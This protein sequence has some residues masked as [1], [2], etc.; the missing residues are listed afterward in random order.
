MKI[1][2][3]RAKMIP[4]YST[5]DYCLCSQD[6]FVYKFLYANHDLA[7]VCRIP[8]KNNSLVTV[9]K[10]VIARSWLYRTFFSKSFGIRHVVELPSG[11]ILI[12]YDRIYRYDP[13][14]HNF[15]AEVVATFKELGFSPPLKNGIAIHPI[16]HNAYFGEYVC[17]IKKRIRIIKISNNGQEVNTCYTFEQDEIQHVH[18][19]HWDDYRKRLWITTGDSDNECAF[20]YTDDE[21]KT[22]HKFSGGDQSWRA[23]SLVF[24]ADNILWGM[25]AGKDAPKEAVNYTYK[26]N[27]TSSKRT[28]LTS[29]ANPTYHSTS[30][31]ANETFWGVNFEPGRKQLTEEAASIWCSDQHLNWQKLF[32][33][34]YKKSVITGVSRYGYVFLPSGI[35]PENTLLFNAVNVDENNFK[36][37]HV[38]N[39]EHVKN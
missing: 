5:L 10:D 4:Q 15:C 27:F 33:L 13:T 26:W 28:K 35:M 30:T 1:K 2:M 9:L 37:M 31:A 3:I 14:K 20:Y 24:N 22:V 17:G 32:T 36:L 34:P 21:F 18:G 6:H 29:F 16:S 23:V 7:K 19:V 25:D 8:T 39:I 38:S 11:V 12:L